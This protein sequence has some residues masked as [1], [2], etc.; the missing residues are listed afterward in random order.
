MMMR[1]IPLC[2][3]VGAVFVT[4]AAG[5]GREE[6][7]RQYEAV[8]DEVYSPRAAAAT[9]TRPQPQ[10]QQEAGERRLLGAITVHQD[11]TWF[12]KLV[13]PAA[14]VTRQ[15]ENFHRFIHSLQFK[16]DAENPIIWELPGP[17]A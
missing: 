11:K 1:K 13:G 8:K 2:L 9:A 17:R 4:L 6:D 3:C 10:P 12:F 16:E 7:V 14:A 5:C 15:A